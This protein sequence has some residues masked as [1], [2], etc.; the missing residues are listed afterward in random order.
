V[1]HLRQTLTCCS[2]RTRTRAAPALLLCTYRARACV[3]LDLLLWSLLGVASGHTEAARG[4]G[5]VVPL[6][7]SSAC[8]A[9][10]TPGKACLAGHAHA[11]RLPHLERTR[12]EALSG[13][14]T[15]FDRT[16]TAENAILLPLLFRWSSVMVRA[17]AFL[18]MRRSNRPWCSFRSVPDAL[19]TLTCELSKRIGTRSPWLPSCTGRR[20]EVQSGSGRKGGPRARFQAPSGGC[21]GPCRA[22]RGAPGKPS[23]Q[24]AHVFPQPRSDRLHCADPRSL[25]T[26]SLLWPLSTCS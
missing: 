15:C 11:P 10:K 20:R 19:R 3:P 22:R 21:S 17:L 7:A 12:R 26:S 2:G 4:G 24:T 13:L 9:S 1:I 23:G 8:S 25:S 14:A 6:G 5:S 18:L 16:R